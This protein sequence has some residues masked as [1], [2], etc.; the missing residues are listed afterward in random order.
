MREAAPGAALSAEQVAA[1]DGGVKALIPIG[2]PFLD[3]ALSALADAGWRRVCLV[4]GPEHED[5]REYCRRLSARRI[6]V[7]TAV[8]EKPL[9]TADAVAAAEAFA[10]GEPFL[11]V[12]SDNY[13]P[14]EALRALREI[15]GPGLAAFERDAMLAG[16]NIP[17][18][19]LR[20]FAALGVGED[21]FLRRIVEK[22]SEDELA[23]MPAPLLVSMNCW[24]LDA[25]IF[26]SCRAIAPSPRGELELTDAVQ[27]AIDCLGVRFRAVRVAASVLDLTGRQ[28]VAPVARVLAGVRVEL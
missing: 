6:R 15:E 11:C 10:A 5:L 22:P 3:Y 4:I 28:D 25:A 8:Q 13:Y 17:A 18:D 24:R 26:Q 19:R 7:E 21:G 14:Q 16:G 23:A 2:R 20:G 27:H 9:G 1:A 12:N